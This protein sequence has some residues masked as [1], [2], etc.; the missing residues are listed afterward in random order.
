MAKIH[1]LMSGATS[2]DPQYGKRVNIAATHSQIF[3]SASGSRRD[4]HLAPRIHEL[5]QERSTT[6]E[7]QR[8]RACHSFGRL[9]TPC[10][11]AL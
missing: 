7:T 10:P 2:D 1:L 9:F 11:N 4:L 6:L 5:D 3:L 8:I